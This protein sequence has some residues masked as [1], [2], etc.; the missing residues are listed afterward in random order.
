MALAGDS[1]P[2]SGHGLCEEYGYKQPQLPRD[3]MALSRH[4]KDFTSL[5]FSAGYLNKEVFP[6]IL[7][8]RY[9]Q[10]CR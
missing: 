9:R 1:G 3:L 4:A 5:A 8:P 2:G 6:C 10:R 7:P